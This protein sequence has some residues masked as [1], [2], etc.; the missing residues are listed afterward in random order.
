[1]VWLSLL[2]AAPKVAFKYRDVAQDDDALGVWPCIGW[3][4]LGVG[5]AGLLG[6]GLTY[7][8]LRKAMAKNGEGDALLESGGCKDGS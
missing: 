7:M 4:S 5:C 8:S 1:M 6:G 2:A 3:F